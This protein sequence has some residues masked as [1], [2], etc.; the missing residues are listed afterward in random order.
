MQ[1]SWATGSEV[2]EDSLEGRVAAWTKS[3]KTGQ[4]CVDDGDDRRG[5]VGEYELDEGR[6]VQT[7]G[8]G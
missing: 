8:V 2:G 3:T 7:C 4:P 1:L 5:R 6:R